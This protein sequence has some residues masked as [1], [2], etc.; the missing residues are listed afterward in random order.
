M[1]QADLHLAS[2]VRGQRATT[3]RLALLCW[4]GANVLLDGILNRLILANIP[5]AALAFTHLA[6]F[7]WPRATTAGAWASAVVRGR[8]A[9]VASCWWAMPEATRGLGRCTEFH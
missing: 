3:A 4:L 9:S 1:L 6:G 8:G 5:V 2:T 7:H